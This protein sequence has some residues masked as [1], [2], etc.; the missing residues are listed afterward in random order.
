[1]KLRVGQWA[2]GAIGQQA[3]R[4]IIE[5]PDMELVG[6]VANNPAKIGL[7]AADLCGFH[8]PTGIAATADNGAALISQKPDCI[9]YCADGAIGQYDKYDDEPTTV[10]NST[11]TVEDLHS[12]CRVLKAGINVVSPSLVPVIH[13]PSADPEIIRPL[14]SACEEGNASCFMTGLDP[15]FMNDV[16][17][18][19]L[20]GLCRHIDSIRVSEVMSYGSWSKAESIINRFGFGKTMDYVP[21]MVRPG[22]IRLIWGCM[23]NL[24]AENLG[25]NLNRIDEFYELHPAPETFAIAAGT[26]EKGTIAAMRFGL[27]GMV[28]GKPI[29][30]F[31]HVTRL[32]IHDASHWPAGV[33][34][35][36]GGYRVEI[37]GEPNWT[38]EIGNP[39]YD[40]PNTPGT[41]ATAQRLV[42][43]IPAVC[44]APA[45]LLTVVDLPIV[46]GRNLVRL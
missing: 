13:P 16:A 24:I 43:A 33:I 37:T 28:G 46:T 5:H 39:G 26:I 17:P 27:H 4:S 41:L 14:R 38:M 22:A 20:S 8:N 1:M 31:E 29:I 40:N 19:I 25:V 34:G 6:V 30:V 42:S 45:G 21:A 12:L 15:G 36:G 2:T 35:P 3:L 23:V 44:A 11:G 32:R 10:W 18:L 9:C 7:D